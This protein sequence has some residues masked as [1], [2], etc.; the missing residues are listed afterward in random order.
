MCKAYF[1][2]QCRGIFM[3]G[4]TC[5]C[6]LEGSMKELMRGSP[7]NVI[8]TKLKGKV[9]RIKNDGIEVLLIGN[10]NRNIKTYSTNQLKKI[11]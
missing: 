10:K 9:Y 5:K 8:G 2:K 3:E 6:A 7:V 4:H 1:C 11:L